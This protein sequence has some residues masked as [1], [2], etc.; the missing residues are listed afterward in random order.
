MKPILFSTARYWVIALVMPKVENRSEIALCHCAE[1][2][3]RKKSLGVKN[4][5]NLKNRGF[6]RFSDSRCG[7]KQGEINLS[8]KKSRSTSVIE[9]IMSDINFPREI[10]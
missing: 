9:L 5:Q 1:F 3:F 2:R 8:Q 10:R 6:H 7:A 4:R